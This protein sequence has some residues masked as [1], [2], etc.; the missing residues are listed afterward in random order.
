MSELLK[1]FA[2]IP[3]RVRE[4]DKYVDATALC[5]AGRE[6]W[7]NYA[8]NLEYQRFRA[9]L[10][11]TT[12][13]PEVQLVETRR[14]NGGGTWV[15]PQIAIDLA[16]WISA[17][18]AVQMSLWVRELLT[19][20]R[21]ELPTANTAPTFDS[22][23]YHDQQLAMMQQTCAALIDTR[24]RQVALERQHHELARQHQETRAAVEELRGTAADVNAIAV[25]AHHVARAALG[26]STSNHGYFTVLGYSRLHNR[27]MPVAE[28]SVHGRRLSALCESR[29][30]APN[31]MND[32]RFGWVNSYPESLL[33]EYFG[34]TEDSPLF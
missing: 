27:E 31:R 32:P 28:A 12:G 16:R 18:F 8:A 6:R 23:D 26:Q 22:S 20:G 5:R 34:D 19:E 10:S 17:D 1:A 21:V 3:V 13:I 7:G 15:H 33:C 25:S 24:R 29:G 2:G 30:I 4:R 11:Q 14:G 9:K